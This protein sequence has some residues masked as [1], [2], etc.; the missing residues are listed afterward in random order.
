MDQT[1]QLKDLK[2]TTE[3]QWLKESPAQILQQSLRNLDQAYKNFFRRISKGQVGKEA[4]FPK[5]KKKGRSLDSFRFPDPSQFGIR[6]VS[7]K[8]SKLKLPKIGEVSFFRS[9]DIEGQIRN[10]TIS[11]E[12]KYWFVSFNCEVEQVQPLNTGTM[13]GIDRGVAKLLVTSEGKDYHLPT[14]IK[15]IEKRKIILQKRSRQKKKF[16]KNWIKTIQ[17]IGTLDRK[18]F[19]IRHDALHKISSEIAKNHSYVV[20]EALNIKNMSKT[21]SGTLQNPG[22]HVKAK[23]GLN[24]SI[25]RQG[26]HKF[27][28]LLEY[29]STWCGG[30]LEYVD[31][32][33]TS[34]RCSVCGHTE[35]DNRL[36]Q[37][38]F[39]CKSCGFELD[40]D[41]NAAIN[42]F[43]RGHRGRACGDADT[44]RVC[45][46]RTSHHVFA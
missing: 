7:R 46:A 19:K 40:A 18:I 13:I 41:L 22:T 33:N 20:L 2:R 37:E 26:W 24:R 38:C 39:H 1:N 42:I 23:S 25:L 15:D 29:K 36:S 8:K 17:R 11:R 44:S 16:S 10:C 21:A 35:K 45:E 5:F 6:K 43:T 14:K 27:Q 9:Q 34:R 28:T 3:T 12:G 30:Y 31:P 32:K 4:G